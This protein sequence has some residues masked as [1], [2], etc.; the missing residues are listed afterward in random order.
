M[1]DVSQA[2][3]GIS[4]ILITPFDKDGQ[5]NTA[6]LKRIAERAIEAGVENLVACGN[7]GEFYAL[8]E[9]EAFQHTRETCAIVEKRACVTAGV[10]RAL[11]TAYRLLDNAER[12]GADAIIL[13]QPLEPFASPDGTVAYVQDIA[14]R[15][16]LP[17]MLYMR[18][19]F[20]SAAEMED[21][22]A[23]ANVLGVKYAVP[24]VLKF[25]MRVR[26]TA[27]LGKKWVCGLAEVYAGAFYAVGGQGFTSG[28]INVVPEISVRI[29]D[30]LASQ[31]FAEAARLVDLISNFEVLRAK[32]FSGNNVTVVK[33]AVNMQGIPVGV[34]RRPG[35]AVLTETDR[36]ELRDVLKSW[37][38][39]FPKVM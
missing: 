5:I 15:T 35:T 34:V 9:Q 30:A 8:D 6:S 18:N 37:S 14:A 2:L 25:A 23:P 4:G 36:N 13:H 24:D 38:V 26:Q 10:G 32:S 33:E 7:T 22:L 21:I 31:D 11:P 3:G 39:E 16:D 28:L 29:R 1:I 19:D 20:F 12:S 27:G 17:I